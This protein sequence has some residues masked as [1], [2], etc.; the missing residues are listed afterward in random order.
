MHANVRYGMFLGGGWLDTVRGVVGHSASMACWESRHQGGSAERHPHLI[1]SESGAGAAAALQFEGTYSYDVRPGPPRHGPNRGCHRSRGGVCDVQGLRPPLPG[2][3]VAQ[4]PAPPLGHSRENHQ[5][6]SPAGSRASG[7][8][9]SKGKPGKS[10]GTSRAPAVA[11]HRVMTRRPRSRLQGQ[12]GFGAGRLIN[13]A[14]GAVRR[15]L[16]TTGQANDDEL[17]RSRLGSG[18]S[19]D[20]SDGNRDGNGDSHQPPETAVNNHVPS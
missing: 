9:R 19:A 18:R 17:A 3:A 1:P 16:A 14:R 2:L 10:Q 8:R 4:A 5:A 12:H 11:S 7:T 6:L 15:L 13:E 20:I